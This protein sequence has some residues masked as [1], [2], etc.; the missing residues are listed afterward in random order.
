MTKKEVIQIAKQSREDLLLHN[1][2]KR[3]FV[4]NCTTNVGKNTQIIVGANSFNEAETK[5]EKSQI[6]KEWS[7]YSEAEYLNNQ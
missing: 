1:P 5:L 6:I 2:D 3:C 7:C 4:F